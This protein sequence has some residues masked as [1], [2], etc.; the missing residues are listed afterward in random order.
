MIPGAV[1]KAVADL[2]AVT[3]AMIAGGWLVPVG[4]Y[5]FTASFHALVWSIVLTGGGLLC[6]LM[7]VLL[8]F[9]IWDQEGL[10]N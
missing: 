2:T 4:A 5:L 8:W 10:N 3:G 9:N 6:D 1:L 7:W